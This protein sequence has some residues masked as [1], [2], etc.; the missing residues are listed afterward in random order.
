MVHPIFIIGEW[1]VIVIAILIL[2]SS[3]SILS[4]LLLITLIGGL[5]KGYSKG[6]GPHLGF[7]IA[8]ITIGLSFIF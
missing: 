8:L 1:I 2:I 4:I 7:F 5:I 6:I 3:F